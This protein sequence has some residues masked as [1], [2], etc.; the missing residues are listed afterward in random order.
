LERVILQ[1]LLVLLNL[2]LTPTLSQKER[3][4]SPFSLREKGWG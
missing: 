4:I 2:S 3:E 1:Q